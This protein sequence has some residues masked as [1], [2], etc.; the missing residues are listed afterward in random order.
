MTLQI[1]RDAA[2]LLYSLY[3]EYKTKRKNG[4]SVVEARNMG[5]AESIRNAIMQM[6]TKEDISSWCI[7]LRDI[8]FMNVSRGS[9]I[10][11]DSWLTTEAVSYMEQR[12]ANGLK[13]AV[14]LISNFV[15]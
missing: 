15:P 13:S 2:N 7:E 8:G 11:Y 12:A 9:N 14:E 10:V 3:G 6:E 1:T 4:A 5:H